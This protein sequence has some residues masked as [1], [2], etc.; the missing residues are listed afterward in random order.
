MAKRKNKT[1]RSLGSLPK[2]LP[3]RPGNKRSLEENPFEVSSRNNNKRSKH[4]VHNRNTTNNS[5]N[6]K[7]SALQRSLERRKL[8]LKESLETSKKTNAFVDR[9]IGEYNP[10][11]TADHK[12]LA[13]L[14]KERSRR[15]KRSQKYSLEDDNINDQQ[16][17]LTHKGRVLTDFDG[18]EHVMLSDSDEDDDDKGNLDALDTQLHFGGFRK[19]ASAYGPA[20][21][22]GGQDLVNVYSQRKTELDEMI[23]RRKVLKAERL[24]HKEQQVE[25]FESM[26]DG[27]QE[28]ASLLQFRDKQKER[29]AREEA[30]R[31]G[32]MS[33][34]EQEMAEWDKE[35]KT[36]LLDRKVKAT[37]RT[38]TPEEIAKEEADRLHELEMRRLA[39]MNGDFDEDDFSDISDDDGKKGRRKKKKTAKAR[40]PDELDDSEEEGNN[41]DMDVRFTADG[42]IYVDKNGVAVK[43]VGDEEHSNQSD[44]SDSDRDG[45]DE[46]DDASEDHHDS[47][48]VL[49]VG[50]RVCGS[51][52]VK[53]QFQ[54]Q[55]SWYEGVIT[56][57]NKQLDGQVTYDV[58]YDDGDVEEAMDPANVRLVKKTQDD[59]AK[60]TSKQ[61]GELAIK[62]K[63]QKAKDKAR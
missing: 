10:T 35:M 57:V 32:T 34:E 54:Q 8:Q 12:M 20:D 3:Q 18:K 36:F 63:Q 19:E 1:K 31:E 39:R 40:N 16:H 38:K 61:H 23:H 62:R 41:N 43:K 24:H 56:K 25:A 11:L 42:L 49:T 14:V 58:T 28:I 44:S 30:R 51:Y 7:Q 60:E 52:R 22:G 15:S 2:G 50:A 6:T 26:D 33:D 4:Q 48:V 13:R 5:N 46:G 27:F 55:G 17:T 45:D 9:R 29:K 59:Q 47:H 37:D 21:G 53:E